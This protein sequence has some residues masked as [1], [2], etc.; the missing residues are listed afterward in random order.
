MVARCSLAAAPLFLL[1]TKFT[2]AV[3]SIT[4]AIMFTK[5]FS[6]ASLVCL[7]AASGTH[8]FKIGS[9][10]RP[11]THFV[12]LVSLLI[13][14]YVT[15][16]ATTTAASSP[17]TTQIFTVAVPNGLGPDNAIFNAAVLG[18]DAASGAVTIRYDLAEDVLEAGKDPNRS[19]FYSSL[20]TL[21]ISNGY[22]LPLF[23]NR[24]PR[25]RNRALHVH[26]LRL[27]CSLHPRPKRKP[28]HVRCAVD[29]CTYSGAYF[30]IV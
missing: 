25:R 12:P 18:S 14:V 30:G 7:A 15:P 13:A 24:S 16:A 1:T 23:R 20:L 4:I 21:I 28:I 9:S 27:F 17:T 29:D 26:H 3:I 22:D 11:H 6:L 10:S 5:L 8:L 19:L 2:T